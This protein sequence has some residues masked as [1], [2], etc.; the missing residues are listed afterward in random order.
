MSEVQHLSTMIQIFEDAIVAGKFKEIDE[1]FVNK[2]PKK[3]KPVVAVTYLRATYPV[4]KKID[5]W[6]DFLTYTRQALKEQNV[7]SHHALRG[8]L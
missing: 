7:I 2:D 8:L 6:Y 5:H 3:M 4:R 1:K